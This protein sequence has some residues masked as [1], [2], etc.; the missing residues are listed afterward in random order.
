MGQELRHHETDLNSALDRVS[1]L[2]KSEDEKASVQIE[3]EELLKKPLD[4]PPP[5]K[6]IQK[7][8]PML[9]SALKK[10]LELT[11][12]DRWNQIKNTVQK[13]GWTIVSPSS[14]SKLAERAKAKKEKL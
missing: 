10:N 11:A 9:D 5:P 12:K 2:K 7:K 8:T 13:G 3:H 1:E 14:K 6:E 4:L